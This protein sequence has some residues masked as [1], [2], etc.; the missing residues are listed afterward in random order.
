MTQLDSLST[1]TRLPQRQLRDHANLLWMVLAC[2]LALCVS[3]CATVVPGEVGTAIVTAHERA[4]VW[5]PAEANRVVALHACT[6]NPFMR[7]VGLFGGAQPEIFLTGTDLRQVDTGPG[8]A[9]EDDALF[10][11]P[12]EDRAHL[13]VDRQDETGARLLGDVFDPDVEPDRA[14]EGRSLRDEDVLQ[15]VAERLFLGIVGEVAALTSPLGNRVDD[16]VDHLAQRVFALG[17]AE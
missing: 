9:L 14:V 7:A 15:L 12:V 1:N 3:G 13:V 5:A 10:P 2:L 16:P 6:K 17:R 4:P 8:A 11:I